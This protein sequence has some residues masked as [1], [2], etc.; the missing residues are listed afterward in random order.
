ML[1]CELYRRDLFQWEILNIFPAIA[2]LLF[3]YTPF[4][5]YY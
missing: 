2:R 5:L 4:N 3:T 1:N